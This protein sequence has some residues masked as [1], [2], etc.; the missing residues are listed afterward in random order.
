MLEGRIHIPSHDRDSLPRSS[1]EFRTCAENCRNLLLD[2]R[3]LAVG[4]A[5]DARSGG[6][7]R[8]IRLPC[9]DLRS[10]IPWRGR[11]LPAA[12]L[13]EASLLLSLCLVEV[14]LFFEC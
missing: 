2:R 14:F 5:D 12:T 3:L 13:I 9:D 1:N 4:F 11:P 6:L 10:R 7:Q 8:Q